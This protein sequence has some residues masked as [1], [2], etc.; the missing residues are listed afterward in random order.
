MLLACLSCLG[1]HLNRCG[2][3]NY[4][5][6]LPVDECKALISNANWST[7]TTFDQLTRERQLGHAF[8]SFR[9]GKL[10]FA[11][12][13]K[14]DLFSD[15]WD[16]SEKCRCPAWTD[17]VLYHGECCDLLHYGRVE[18][19]K[20]SDHRPVVALIKIEVDRIDEYVRDAVR[21]EVLEEL[22]MRHAT[23]AVY[24][25]SSTVDAQDLVCLIIASTACQCL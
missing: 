23:V 8:G 21:E 19:L 5:I 15:D 17:R 22:R 10:D 11:P 14:Y 6:E 2:D 16:T 3:F 4:R 13:Y 25:V 9:E 12:T 20:T 7:L 1:I 24:P 18:T